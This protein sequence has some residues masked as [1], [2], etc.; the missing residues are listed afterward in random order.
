MLT[1]FNAQY[2]EWMTFLPQLLRGT[3]STAA[4]ATGFSEE[5][6]GVTSPLAQAVVR[7]PLRRTLRYDRSRKHL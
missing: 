6:K 1:F 5:P 4:S 2:W 7:K 3:Q